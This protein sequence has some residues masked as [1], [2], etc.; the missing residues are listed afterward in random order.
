MFN[1]CTTLYDKDNWL[2]FLLNFYQVIF[3]LSEKISVYTF[4]K[5]NMIMH[6]SD[7]LPDGYHYVEIS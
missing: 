2:V 1:I 6:V 7:K 4:P 5:Y 3:C